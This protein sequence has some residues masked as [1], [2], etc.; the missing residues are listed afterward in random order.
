MF[1]TYVKLKILLAFLAQ[2]EKF[3]KNKEMQNKRIDGCFSGGDNVWT[4]RVRE[5][6]CVESRHENRTLY[7][8]QRDI[9]FAEW[10]KQE[11]LLLK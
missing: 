2:K 7:F 11:K 8:N 9:N 5:C 6:Y 3:W 10:Q 1:D 4:Q